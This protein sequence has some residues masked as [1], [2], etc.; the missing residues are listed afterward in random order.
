MIWKL[1][2]KNFQL[3]A[4]PAEIFGKNRKMRFFG[5]HIDLFEEKICQLY[6]WK[7]IKWSILLFSMVLSPK[8]CSRTSF[9]AF[10]SV[11][12]RDLLRFLFLLHV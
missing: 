12:S 4:W 10:P 1:A 9:L 11:G 5:T 8:L 7:N 2:K 6:F 3:H